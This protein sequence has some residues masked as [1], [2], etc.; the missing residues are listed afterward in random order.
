MAGKRG[1]ERERDRQEG[2]G[3]QGSCTRCY[4]G[5]HL[6]AVQ[7]QRRQEVPASVAIQAAKQGQK[8]NSSQ[9]EHCRLV[10]PFCPIPTLVSYLSVA[11]TWEGLSIVYN[12]E[13]T[14]R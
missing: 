11:K 7:Q 8:Y 14:E 1:E 12:D 3:E 6:T 10:F 4:A 5:G 9:A 2:K 13:T